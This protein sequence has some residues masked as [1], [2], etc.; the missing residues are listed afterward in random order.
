MFP[1]SRYVFSG[2]LAGEAQ[3]GFDELAALDP[4]FTASVDEAADV[5]ELLYN[6]IIEFISPMVRLL[7]LP[8]VQHAVSDLAERLLLTVHSKQ[9][10]EEELAAANE[11]AALHA[12]IAPLPPRPRSNRSGSGG[13]ASMW[14]HTAD[15]M[16]LDRRQRFAY[17]PGAAPACV[18]RVQHAVSHWLSVFS[19]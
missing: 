19:L 17:K 7:H 2:A 8:S 15:G 1:G 4:A 10:W 18:P 14:S 5:W 3:P 9:A 16:P 11:T 13:G 6:N 12:A